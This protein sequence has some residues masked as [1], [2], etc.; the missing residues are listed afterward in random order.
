[1]LKS[2]LRYALK[3]SKV[4]LLASE[5]KVFFRNLDVY[6]EERK[7][8]G[9]TTNCKKCLRKFIKCY[10]ENCTSNKPGTDIIDIFCSY[11]LDH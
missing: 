2:S 4:F 7:L 6:G 10:L 9:K 1:M 8:A 11:H 3:I 5:E